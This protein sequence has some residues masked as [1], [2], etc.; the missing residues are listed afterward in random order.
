MIYLQNKKGYP[1]I[2]IKSLKQCCCQYT[3]A[4]IIKFR[5]RI[6]ISRLSALLEIILIPEKKT[7]ALNATNECFEHTS[8]TVYKFTPCK[9]RPD[10][11]LVTS[12]PKWIAILWSLMVLATTGNHS[13]PGTMIY[14]FHHE[15]DLARTTD[16]GNQQWILI[17]PLFCGS[18]PSVP[19]P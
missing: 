10:G 8:H 12:I 3:Y 2:Y 5:K 7:K 16:Q 4:K 6:T 13:L 9:Q 14:S 19:C 1:Q 11:A 15:L 18:Y 17:T